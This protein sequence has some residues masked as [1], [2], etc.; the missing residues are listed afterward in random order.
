MR[1]VLV[2]A[3]LAALAIVAIAYA[4][5]TAEAQSTTIDVG[6]F[7]FCN[8]S[9]E[10]GVCDTTVV[11]GSTVTWDVSSGIH[12]VTECDATFTTCP[13]PGGFDSG[14]M[15][16]AATFSQT[17][18]TPG[19]FPYYCA[20]HPTQMR[21]RVLVQSQATPTAA[22]TSAGTPTGSTATTP[23]SASASVAPGTTVGPAQ[24]PAGGGDPGGT[25]RTGAISLGILV[26]GVLISAAAVTKLSTVRRRR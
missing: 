14:T 25:S 4:S 3:P 5:L 1:H 20:F 23:P 17:F 12:T 8:S 21:G 11:T 16:A 6:D 15:N 2:S 9:F 10:V 24:V 13:P 18:D 22:P 19:T 26:T 7:W